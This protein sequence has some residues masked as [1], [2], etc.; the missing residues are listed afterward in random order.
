[1][2]KQ[3]FLKDT[4]ISYLNENNKYKSVKFEYP[5]TKYYTYYGM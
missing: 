4:E 5:S 1:M 3:I 2:N